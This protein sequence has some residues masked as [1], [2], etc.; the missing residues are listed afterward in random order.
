[1]APHRAEGRTACLH[2]GQA[3]L[4]LNGVLL[5]NGVSVWQRR[6]WEGG[7]LFLSLGSRRHEAPWGHGNM[8]A[9]RLR[10]HGDVRAWR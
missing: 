10:G 5:F 7:S 1:M 6:W 2:L 9:W 3:W 4:L 8:R